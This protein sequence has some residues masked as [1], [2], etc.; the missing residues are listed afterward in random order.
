MKKFEK[1]Q[2]AV[3]AV[4]T[5]KNI[6]KINVSLISNLSDV[7]H[8]T[9]VKL[10]EGNILTDYDKSLVESFSDKSEEVHYNFLTRGD[11]TIIIPYMSEIPYQTNGKIL[12]CETEYITTP[13]KFDMFVNRQF[14][15][16]KEKLSVGV[17]V[18]GRGRRFELNEDVDSNTHCIY[19][20]YTSQQYIGEFE[21]NEVFVGRELRLANADNKYTFLQNKTRKTTGVLYAKKT[22]REGINNVNGMDF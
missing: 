12:P 14:N 7:I 9:D 1:I 3:S 20:G 6:Y 4:S 19:D 15:H 2:G 11:T 21:K 5:D 8:F 13:I 22:L 17:G 18:T 10:Q 16:L